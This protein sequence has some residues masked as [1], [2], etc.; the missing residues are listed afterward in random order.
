M[1]GLTDEQI[2]ELKLKDEW[3]AKCEPSGGHVFKKDEIGRRNGNGKNSLT[4]KKKNFF[5]NSTTSSVYLKEHLNQSL[6]KII[7][8]NAWRRITSEPVAFG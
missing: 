3:A 7:T 2:E 8:A 5:W 6:E 1:Q 4:K